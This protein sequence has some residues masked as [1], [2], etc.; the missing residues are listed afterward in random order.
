MLSYEEGVLNNLFIATGTSE[1][2]K[3]NNQ[4]RLIKQKRYVQLKFARFF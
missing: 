4:K 3:K 1:T 2:L